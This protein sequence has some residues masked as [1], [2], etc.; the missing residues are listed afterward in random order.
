MGV[1]YYARVGGGVSR[2]VRYIGLVPPYY[3]LPVAVHQPLRLGDDNCYSPY[4]IRIR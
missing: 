1:Y 4:V 3:R 2:E